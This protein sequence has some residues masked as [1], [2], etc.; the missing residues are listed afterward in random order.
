MNVTVTNGLNLND[1]HAISASVT[2]TQ[3]YAN[4]L[5]DLL[6]FARR[7]QN[8]DRIAKR[9]DDASFLKLSSSYYECRRLYFSLSR[10][11]FN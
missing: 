5:S 7:E 2:Y 11:A 3:Y 4:R 9:F 8:L 10:D 6:P 1:T